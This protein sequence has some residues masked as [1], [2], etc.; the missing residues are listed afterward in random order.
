[1]CARSNHAWKAICLSVISFEE[2]GEVWGASSRLIYSMILFFLEDAGPKPYLLNFRRMYDDGYNV[3]FLEKI[4]LEQLIEFRRLVEKFARVA[5]YQQ[6][7][8][9]EMAHESIRANLVKLLEMTDASIARR[10]PS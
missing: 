8:A 9:G 10:R 3:L 7:F 2:N 6:V 4:S 1:M 5:P